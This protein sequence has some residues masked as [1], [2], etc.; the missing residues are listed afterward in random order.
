MAKI[1]IA[2][3]GASE[4]AYRRFLPALIKD[5]RFEYVG[6]AYER[7]QDAEKV[8]DFKANYGGH[9]FTSFNDVFNDPS[10]DAVYVPQPP[11]FHFSFGKRVLESGKHLFMEKPF[12]IDLKDTQTLIN[13]AK[14]KKLGVVENYMFRFHKQIKAFQDLVLNEDLIGKVKKYEVRFSFPRRATTDFRYNKKLGGGALFDCGGYTIML[15][16]IL[17]ARKGQI[18]AFRPIYSDEFEVDIGGEGLFEN[19]GLKCEFSFGMDNPY[20]CYAKAYG[21]KGILIANRVLTAPS[22]FDVNFDILDSLGNIIRQI[23]I[24]IDD[25]FL[26]SIDNFYKAVSENEIRKENY[27]IITR[28]AEMIEKVKALGGIK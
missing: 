16:D 19:K 28:Q 6:V 2:I 5:Q 18:T 15:S 23:N 14:D 22:D 20:F 26:K 12:T 11:A 27:E 1:R 25:S 21:E 9:I 8:L 3:L 7:E 13:I 10:V 24:G 4:I 17:L